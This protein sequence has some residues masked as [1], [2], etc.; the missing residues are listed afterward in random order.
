M[1][2]V[3]SLV[4]DDSICKKIAFV[5]NVLAPFYLDYPTNSYIQDMLN[6]ITNLDISEAERQWPFV[7]PSI[8]HDALAL[9]KANAKREMRDSLLWEYRRL[10]V[11]PGASPAPP[12][13]S[14]YTDP[15][16][17]VFGASTLALR[18]WLTNNQTSFHPSRNIPE[19]HIGLMLELMSLIANEKPALLEEYLFEHFYTWAPRYLT[20]LSETTT[21]PFYRGLAELTKHSLTGIM[22][23]LKP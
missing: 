18:E 20:K 11:G 13:G 8:C 4:M 3:D 2:V 6:E 16:G 15:D 5:G 23:T 10:F 7:E 1:N 9:M 21:H 19:D 22:N 12:W 17:V 14:V